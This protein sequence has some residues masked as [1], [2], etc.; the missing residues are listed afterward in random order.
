MG[1]NLIFSNLLR[2]LSE[3]LQPE[4]QDTGSPADVRRTGVEVR[5]LGLALEGFSVLLMSRLRLQAVCGRCRK[6]LDFEVP[7]AGGTEACTAPCVCPIC[8][9]ELALRVAPDI[10]HG[11]CPTIAHVL[12]V[13][14]HPV[15]FLRS[16]FQGTCDNCSEDA[17]I[18]GAGAGYR[19]RAECPKCYAKL[20]LAIE[21]AELLG[22][23]VE[24]WRKIAEE[25]GDQMN[26]RKRLQEA[27]RQ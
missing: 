11:G 18:R 21:G 20:N 8:K 10:C 1:K 15:Q 13:N 12:G 23:A 16:D 22:P 4:T 27:R 5:L 6:P 25:G 24:R 19:K 7:S 14:C 26:A 2:S 9:Q 17:C 3:V